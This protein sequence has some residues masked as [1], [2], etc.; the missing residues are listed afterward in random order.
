MTDD[1]IKK[2]LAYRN[3]EQYTHVIEAYKKL[4]HKDQNNKFFL[5]A[6]GD[7]S[8]EQGDD[9]EALRAYLAFAT[10]HPKN[11]G[12]NYALFGAAV[13]LKN[14]Q[15]QAEA[16]SVLDLI[17]K[18]HLELKEEMVH[19]VEILHKQTMAKEILY[20]FKLF[21]QRSSMGTTSQ[22]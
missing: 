6:Y 10:Q 5:M 16:K 18:S 7:S 19:S 14:L 22:A 21:Q 2:L 8:Y 17:D 4:N 20:G 1:N 11:E 12:R 13:A 3:C 9:L 15:L